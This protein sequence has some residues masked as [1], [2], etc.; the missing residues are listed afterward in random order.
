MAVRVVVTTPLG[1]EVVRFLRQHGPVRGLHHLSIALQTS[2]SWL[3]GIVLDLE[4]QGAVHVDRS[5]RPYV[6]SLCEGDEHERP[7]A[8]SALSACSLQPGEPVGVDPL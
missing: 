2:Y 3:R 7:D 1:A 6:I 4:E 8:V 5:Q